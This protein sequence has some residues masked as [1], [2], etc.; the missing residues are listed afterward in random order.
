MNDIL[1]PNEFGLTQADGPSQ[2]GASVNH[3]QDRDL[4]LFK[5]VSCHIAS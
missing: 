4:N 2:K 1:Q 5:P 3:I